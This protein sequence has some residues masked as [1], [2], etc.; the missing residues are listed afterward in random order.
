MKRLQ[1]VLEKKEKETTTKV[2]RQVS[3]F[4]GKEAKAKEQEILDIF[5]DLSKKEIEA[6]SKKGL[7][8]TPRE[9]LTKVAELLFDIDG[10]KVT[11][12]TKSSYPSVDLVDPKTGKKLTPKQIE[13]GVK[14][15]IRC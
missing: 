6:R 2:D 15:V 1:I 13:K 3:T 7:A 14:G 4:E 10:T 5:K 12:L 11:D 9:E 8:G